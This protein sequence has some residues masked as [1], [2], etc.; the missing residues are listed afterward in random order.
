M[1]KSAYAQ[2]LHRIIQRTSFPSNP[3]I[4][5]SLLSRIMLI[6]ALTGA[7]AVESTVTVIFIDRKMYLATSGLRTYLVTLQH[8]VV[9]NG[10]GCEV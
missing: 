7:L 4:S 9:R 10:G 1:R 3:A 2:R 5:N 6:A 8:L